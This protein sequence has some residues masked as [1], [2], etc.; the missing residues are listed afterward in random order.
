M[1]ITVTTRDDRCPAQRTLDILAQADLRAADV[2][3]I[4][5]RYDE[6]ALI[7]LEA[8]ASGLKAMACGAAIVSTQVPGTSALGR[9]SQLVP[10]EDPKSLAKAVDALP[11]DPQRRREL[12]V[13]A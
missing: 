8:M 12:G 7:L 2:V 9:A 10:V 1:I 11:A 13:A 3:V 6:M 5:S 4:P